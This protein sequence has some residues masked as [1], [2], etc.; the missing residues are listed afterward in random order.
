MNEYT[1]GGPSWPLH[2]DHSDLVC[3]LHKF[4]A[5]G[6][7]GGYVNWFRIYLS[8][9]ESQVR[10]AVVL[11]SPFEIPSGVLQGSVLG[12]V[13]FDVFINNICNAVAHSKCLLFTDIRI[14]QAVIP[15]RAAIHISV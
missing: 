3:F 6:L 13:L 7:S 12:P 4:S 10:V 15:P 9:R 2:R 5:I 8:S 11:S 14:Y 1:R